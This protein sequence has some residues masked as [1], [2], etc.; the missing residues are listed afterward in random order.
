MAD[1]ATQVRTRFSERFG[2]PPAA[3][4]RAP[5]RVN[6][7]GEHTDYNEGYVFPI[8]IDRA[9]YIAAQPRADRTVHLVS[10]DF[11]QVSEFSLHRIE[12]DPVAPWSNYVRGVAFF[13]EQRGL[14]LAGMD[15]VISGDVPLGAGLSSSAAIELATATAFQV[16]NRFEM[17]G[18]ELALLGQRAENEFVGMRCG[19]MDQF[20]A[21]LGQRDHA[22]LIDCRRLAYRPVPLPPSVRVVVCDTGKRRGLVDSEYNLRRQQCETGVQLLQ[23]HL[24][25][26]RALRDVSPDDFER[27]RADLPEVARQR[28]EHV[29]YE[30]E[31]V[32]KSVAALESG[33]VAGF[34][35][36]MDESHASLRDLYQVSCRELDIMVEV[37]RRL[38]GC[39]GA[40]MTGA[41]FGGATVS[42]VEAAATAD[43]SVRVADGY[44]AAT[45]LEPAIYVTRAEDGA[46]IL[47]SSQVRPRRG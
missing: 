18:V 41:G 15:A 1:R 22:L 30:D 39:L 44:R 40:R 10:L 11:D 24:P 21:A 42:L 47:E 6:L 33:D 26:I 28:V 38:P 13:L 32:L 7:I 37:A 4:V 36:L 2:A 16:L 43:F 23:R 35:R 46:G 14:R 25:H 5:G 20:I 17:N 45:D 31:R 29:V 8:A 9:V 19:I 12:P 34:G 27:Y 3:V